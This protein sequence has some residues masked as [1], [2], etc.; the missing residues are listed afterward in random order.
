MC[1]P[2]YWWWKKKRGQVCTHTTLNFQKY[3]DNPEYFEFPEKYGT[4]FQSKVFGI[5]WYARSNLGREFKN[6][7][8]IVL[9]VGQSNWVRTLSHQFQ[10][11]YLSLTNQ[12]FS[13]A[14]GYIEWWRKISGDEKGNLQYY[15]GFILFICLHLHFPDDFIDCS[16]WLPRYF[17]S[18]V[19][20]K[21]TWNPLPY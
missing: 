11:A 20:N 19:C 14:L 16:A 8:V 21:D 6:L 12:V 4:I 9:L 10:A 5:E 1:Y 17:S 2:Y 13:W 7:E 18:V 3:F 15:K